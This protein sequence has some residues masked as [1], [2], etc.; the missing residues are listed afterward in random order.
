MPPDSVDASF[1]GDLCNLVSN[2]YSLVSRMH[3][4][5]IAEETAKRATRR[6]LF[7]KVRRVVLKG[8]L[9]GIALRRKLW[10][11]C[12]HRN[13]ISYVVLA[14]TF[15]EV[16]AR[17][18]AVIL[19]SRGLCCFHLKNKRHFGLARTRTVIE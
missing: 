6:I 16:F 8:S 5:N 14:M 7:A 2:V 11:R 17:P 10:L 15:A 12:A 3:A 18:S 4:G 13:S 1:E 19:R 9:N